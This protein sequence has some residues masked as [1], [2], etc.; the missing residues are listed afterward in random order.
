MFEFFHNIATIA[1][2]ASDVWFYI[3]PFIFY[4]IFIF[5][6]I[7]SRNNVFGG[8]IEWVLL[9]IVAPKLLEKSPHPME[10]IYSGF[11][12]V[13]KTSSAYEEFIL[14]EYPVSFSLELV[15]AEGKVHMFIRT[16]KAFRNLVEA[17]FYAQYPDVEIVEAEDYTKQVPRT[18]PNKDW[19]LWGTEFKLLKPDLYP[20]RTYKFFEE[21]VTGKMLDPMA[22]L[23][24]TMG[25]LGPGQHLWLQ[26]IATP[27]K[28]DWGP[29]KGALTIE[30]FLGHEEVER[31]GIFSRVWHDL[32]DV[33]HNLFSGMMGSELEWTSQEEAAKAE[34]QPVEFRLT[35]G[36]K[37]ILKA[38]ESNIGK[39][40]FKIKMRHVYLGKK[41]HF[42]K[43]TGVSAFIGAI[44][45]FNDLAM[46][47]MI[48]DDLTKTYASYVMVEPR[49]RYRQRRLLRRYITRDPDPQENRFMFSSEELA[50]IYHLPD[51]QVLAPSFSRVMTK[52]GGAPGNLPVQ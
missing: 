40:M 38:L 12:G 25:K 7:D 28:E 16:Q 23:I 14:G 4:P 1:S 2:V 36:Q 52:R 39:P 20:I 35:P 21:S 10:L 37:D 29:K 8:K 47:S 5:L 19:D 26:F 50:T 3:I 46:N 32:A 30:E 17:H 45:Q 51:M 49:L 13:I 43:A 11:A 42:S 6:W 18:V 24:E 48:P 44:K 33:F 34:E 9:E 15:S 27:V 41:E 22:G 31:P